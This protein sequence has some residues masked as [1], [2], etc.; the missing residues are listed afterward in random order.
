MVEAVVWKP[1]HVS[2]AFEERDITQ[3]VPN[4]RLTLLLFKACK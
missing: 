1:L 3:W 4:N 2:D